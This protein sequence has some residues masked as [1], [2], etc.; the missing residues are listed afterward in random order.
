VTTYDDGSVWPVAPSDRDVEIARLVL[1]R[2]KL[3]S[4]VEQSWHVLEPATPFKA[5]WHIDC[6]CEHLEA[7]TNLDIQNLILNVPPGSAK[8]LLT[9]VFWPAWEWIQ[10]PHKRWLFGSYKENLALR[11]SRKMRQLIR[12][13]WYQSRF[14]H[15]YQI[16]KNQDA[17]GRFENDKTGIRIAAGVASATGERCDHVTWDDPHNI[18]AA[19]SDTTRDQVVGYWKDTWD[20]RIADPATS[21]RLI[22]MQRLHAKD[23]SG[24]ML[25]EQADS[26]EHLS[27]PMEYEGQKYF[28]TS[29]GW[30]DP[31]TQEGDLLWPHHFT[32]I[33][34]ERTKKALGPYGY[35]GQFQQ[36][37]SPREG[38]L[39]KISDFKIVDAVPAIAHRVRCWDNAGTEGAGDYTW[40]TLMAKTLDGLYWVEDCVYGKWSPT[41]RDRIKRETA[42]KDKQKY[43]G[44]VR[45][46]DTQDP[47]T[48]G[49]EAAAASIRNL[50]GYSI[51]VEYRSAAKNAKI[52]NADPWASQCGAGNVRMLK[53]DWNNEFVLQ[54]ITFPNGVHDDAVDA[55]DF[56]EAKLAPLGAFLQGWKEKLRI[57]FDLGFGKR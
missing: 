47:G 19:E 45:T 10:Y 39:F 42:E 11:D 48:A 17:K 56:A 4:F 5:N 20:R 37:P 23:V 13:Q 55:T 22:I 57:N 1:A 24:V 44:A 15:I 28:E 29:L 25:L 16:D 54:H 36:R 53:A 21:T 7:M 9:G 38:G 27:I 31:R 34:N 3:R 33:E 52:V 6:I 49:K 18:S 26:W 40:G 32:D 41:E 35:S 12:S 2:K 8:S 50:A 51:R 30:K 14:G 43:G 46:F